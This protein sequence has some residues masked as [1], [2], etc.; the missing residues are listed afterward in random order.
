MESIPISLHFSRWP[1]EEKPLPNAAPDYLVLVRDYAGVQY[2]IG[3]YSELGWNLAGEVL[4]W[5][6][7]PLHSALYPQ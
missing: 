1:F 2:A 7:L 4:S 3:Q 6:E 5:A